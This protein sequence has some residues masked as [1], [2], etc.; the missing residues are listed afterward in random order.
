[1]NQLHFVRIRFGNDL[2]CV[3]IAC[4]PKKAVYAILVLINSFL[5]LRL[6]PINPAFQASNLG[7][8][9]VELLIDRIYSYPCLPRIELVDKAKVYLQG[10][11]SI[12]DFHNVSER[13]E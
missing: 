4:R 3:S 8:K 12:A 5:N 11:Q 2:H 13:K 9:T 1:M 10:S 7:Y 6:M